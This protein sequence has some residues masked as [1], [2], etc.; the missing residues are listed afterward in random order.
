MPIF[1]KILA[2][3]KQLAKSLLKDETPNALENSNIFNKADKAYIIK[4]LTDD[5]L[6]KQRIKLKN[7]IRKH[8]DWKSISLKIE[9]NKKPSYWKYVAAAAIISISVSSYFFSKQNQNNNLENNIVIESP[10]IV[11]GTD[12]ATLTLGNGS[13][14][15][16]E[17]G[18][19]FKTNKI[20]SNG[21]SL[22]YKEA[23]AHTPTKVEYNTLTTKRGGQFYV[24]LSDGTQVWLNSESQ[25]KFPVDFVEGETRTVELVYGE[26]YFDVSP[27]S[28]HRGQSFKVYNNSQE[29]NVLGTEFNIKA[30]KDE[31]NIY[32]TL[33]EGRVTV[34]TKSSSKKLSPNQQLNL[35]TATNTLSVAHVDVYNE[36]SWKDGIFSFEEKTLK[37]IMKVL[38]RWY[39]MEVVFID[40]TIEKEEF[41]GIIGKDQS[42]EYILKSI[43]S[44]GI[45][46][47]YKINDKNVIL[48]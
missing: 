28:N 41:N 26:A 25:I 40:T 47:K 18:S 4:H 48:E 9:S 32:T 24:V 7:K 30:Y 10:K 34:S 19:N 42:I 38:S 15:A 1:T 37:D 2:L 8:D 20:S 3:S 33:V 35:N 39:D 44:Y 36:I 11:P 31:S 17:K 12:K 16:L 29:V 27:S 22:I 6:I 46:K 14:I 21:Q 23:K 45:I 43:K 5:D 13:V